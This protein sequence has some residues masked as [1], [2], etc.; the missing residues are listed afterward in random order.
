MFRDYTGNAALDRYD[1]A[2][3][4]DDDESIA[5][6]DDAQRRLAELKMHRRDRAE[7]KGRHAARSHAPAFMQFEDDDDLD[8]AEII[9]RR[10]RRHYDEQQ[11][12]D[13]EGADNDMPLEQIADVKADS[14]AQW[15][16]EV[17]VRNTIAREFRNFL[18]TYVD[19]R[20]V[21]VYGQ[22]VKALGECKQKDHLIVGEN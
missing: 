9:G 19:D 11:D 13:D 3:G 6:M 2:L 1:A 10:R 12:N 4:I 21:S 14:I 18:V 17:G 5:A 8:N 15:I 16:A 7:G 20:G 22:R